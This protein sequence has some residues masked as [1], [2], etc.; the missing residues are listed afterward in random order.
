LL[1]GD[2]A[3]QPTR[4]D[5]LR[6]G[7]GSSTLL[8]WGTSVPT[9]LAHSAAALSQ[10][11]NTNRDGKVLVVLFLGGGND[12]LNTIVPSRDPD[13]QRL[14]PVI[15]LAPST[16]LRIDDR[17]GFH[18]S[19]AGLARLLENRQLAVIQGVG[20]PN[21]NRSHFESMI[22]WHTARLDAN[23]NTAGWLARWLDGRAPRPGGDAS[24]LHLG[25]PP[26]PQ[27][28]T[29]GRGQIPSV[30][31]PDQL[32]RRLGLPESAEARAQRAALDQISAEGEAGPDSLLQ[33]V[34]RSTVVS[35]TSSARLAEV[36][37]RPNQ[38]TGYPAF[39]V[40]Q[41]LSLIA[42]L[43]KAGLGTSLYYTQL[44]CPSGGSRS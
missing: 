29:G 22:A 11:R 37:G 43:I 31:S 15:R 6:L 36:F 9:F 39:P 25:V 30:A 26:L 12:G 42:Q 44:R 8:A 7:L 24:A 23:A 21:P 5:F 41:R 27:G 14:R 28:L 3:M 19:L 32:R 40:A 17:V 13:Y 33:F 16:L 10:E 34:Q 2:Q 35:Y 20:Y 4:R 18:P 1:E 38:Q